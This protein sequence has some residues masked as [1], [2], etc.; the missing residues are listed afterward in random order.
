LKVHV[1]LREETRQNPE[2]RR[3]ALD[4]IVQ[5]SGMQNVNQKRFE[6]YGIITGEVEDEAR[7]KALESL[8]EVGSVEKDSEKSAI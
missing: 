3:A 8:A 7:M 2:A 1:T 5:A 6:R 4:K